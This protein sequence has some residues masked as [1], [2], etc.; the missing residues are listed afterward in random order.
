MVSKISVKE[1]AR[2]AIHVWGQRAESAK[3]APRPFGPTATPKICP[4]SLTA[5]PMLFCPKSIADKSTKPTRIAT[6]VVTR[7]DRITPPLMFFTIKKIV[8]AKPTRATRTA[9]LLKSTRPGVAAEL[10]VI[11]AA[12]LSAPLPATV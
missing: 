2:I 1:K 8:M 11:A 3:R 4:S 5:V 7:M 12:A 6:T 9:G 10:A